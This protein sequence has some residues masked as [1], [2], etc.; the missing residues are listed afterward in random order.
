MTSTSTDYILTYIPFAELVSRNAI[1]TFVKKI[2]KTSNSDINYSFTK[3]ELTMPVIHFHKYIKDNHF[4]HEQIMAYKIARRRYNNC[5][6]SCNARLKRKMKHMCNNSNSNSSSNSSR[7]S[8]S[9][10]N[11]DSVI[12]NSETFEHEIIDKIDNL[13]DLIHYTYK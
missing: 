9:N 8:R 5:I 11:T 7:S 12:E 10:T 13:P 4:T 6:Y 3:E 2:T 1:H